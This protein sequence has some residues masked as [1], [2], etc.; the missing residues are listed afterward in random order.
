MF[1]PARAYDLLMS[2]RPLAWLLVA[3]SASWVSAARAQRAALVPSPAWVD[4]DPDAEESE[5]R[6]A[7]VGLGF[8]VAGLGRGA[9][10]TTE[11]GGSFELRVGLDLLDWLG[12][13]A[14]YLGVI[15]D[16]VDA[17]VGD[18]VEVTAHGGSVV[19]RVTLAAGWY[20]PYLFAGVGGYGFAVLG[21]PSQAPRVELRDTAALALPLGLGIEIRLPLRLRVLLEGG[22]HALFF[23]RLAAA[24][25]H[26]SADLWTAAILLKLV[27]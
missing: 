11:P 25:R 1:A 13:E 24:P 15:V 12:L 18:D 20:T 19:A 8:G 21:D 16:G 22:Y 2:R 17:L 4:E 7:S 9:A 6:R 5:R 27:L 3:A 10:R 14:R 26:A 23:E